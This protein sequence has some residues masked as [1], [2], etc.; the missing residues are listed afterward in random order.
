MRKIIG[1]FIKKTIKR[2]LKRLRNIQKAHENYIY[3]YS[4]EI[5]K[6]KLKKKRHETLFKEYKKIIDDLKKEINETINR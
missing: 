6:L 2:E 3:Q 5:N 1:Y 4:K